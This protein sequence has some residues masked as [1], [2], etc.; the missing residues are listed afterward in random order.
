M[1]F[2][3]IKTGGK[4][5]VVAPG[6]ALKVEKL[7]ALAG[8]EIVFDK[9]LLAG[10]ENGLK[11]GTPILQDIKIVAEV[12]EQGR[13]KKITVLKYKNKTRYR[14]KRGHRQPYTKVKITE[15]KTV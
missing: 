7:P 4:Q 8:R 10:D 2:A 1:K 6:K 13:D 5:Y 3:V 9:V 14:V 11:I 15:I 12:A